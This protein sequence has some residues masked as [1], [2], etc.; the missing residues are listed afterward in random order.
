MLGTVATREYSLLG[1]AIFFRGS[2][3]K[4]KHS[5]H[6]ISR[7]MRTAQGCFLRQLNLESNTLYIQ[8]F[9]HHIFCVFACSCI[10]NYEFVN[11]LQEYIAKQFGFMQA[12]IGYDILAE[13]TI[14]DLVHNNR[15][16]LEKHITRTEIETFVNLVRKKKEC[17]LVG[18]FVHYSVL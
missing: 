11:L 7:A 6:E 15:K 8:P 14:T 4:T 12:Q 2:S 5:L 18:W 17:R 16:L 1:F 10:R 3:A 9:S 13:D